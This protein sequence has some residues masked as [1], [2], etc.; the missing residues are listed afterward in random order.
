MPPWPVVIILLAVKEKNDNYKVSTKIYK[1]LFWLPSSLNLN[2][3]KIS[4]V[5]NLIKFFY[6]LN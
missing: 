6:K 3:K 5:C 4:Q 2:E 1:N